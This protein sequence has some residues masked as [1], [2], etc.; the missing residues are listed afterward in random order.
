MGW[1]QNQ[2]ARHEAKLAGAERPRTGGLGDRISD[3]LDEKVE[4][5]KV[6]EAEY[7]KYAE[8]ERARIAAEKAAKRETKAEAKAARK[9]GTTGPE[10]MPGPAVSSDST[11]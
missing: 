10:A 4:A 9:A 1:Y 11:P 3:A 2:K 8:A 6:R 5:S 7:R